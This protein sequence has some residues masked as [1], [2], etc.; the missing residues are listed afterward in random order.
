VGKTFGFLLHGKNHMGFAK[1]LPTE[2]LTLL[3]HC[4]ET[5]LAIAESI[6]IQ[7]IIYDQ[8]DCW[9][10]LFL[11]LDAAH[12]SV[13]VHVPYITRQGLERWNA[14]IDALIARG[15]TVTFI[16][17]QPS[18]WHSRKNPEIDR[19]ERNRM[20]ALELLVRQLQHQGV[21]VIL[22]KRI[23]AKFVIIDEQILWEGSLNFLSFYKTTEHVRRSINRKEVREVRARHQLN[24]IPG[25]SS[26]SDSEESLRQVVVARRQE[27]GLAQAELAAVVSLRQ[28]HLSRI[29]KGP[30][31]LLSRGF[32]RMLMALDLKIVVV[33]AYLASAVEEF[34]RQRHRQSAQKDG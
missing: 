5:I 28:S 29:E 7:T 24:E 23:H 25:Y 1:N 34:I 14:K 8:S 18:L 3:L 16:L 2:S 13:V 22:R 21:N 19:N 11:D 6:L 17:Q 12:G 20:N 31:N 30:A 32:R 26:K 27:L 9:G 4:G 33:P 15:V 10:S